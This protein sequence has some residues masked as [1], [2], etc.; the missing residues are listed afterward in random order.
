[1]E[2]VRP[3]HGTPAGRLRLGAHPA[4]RPLFRYGWN[5]PP[6]E[7]AEAGTSLGWT[8]KTVSVTLPTPAY[9]TNTLYVVAV[10]S[11]GNVGYSSL[12][13]QVPAP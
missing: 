3:E 5:S 7:E 11:V 2:E 13:I 8:G 9:G 4:R 1:M 6:T 10:D 12:V